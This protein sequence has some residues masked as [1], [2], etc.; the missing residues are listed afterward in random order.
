MK[1]AMFGIYLHNLKDQNSKYST[2]GKNPFDYVY[3]GNCGKL[4]RFIKVYDPKS[5]SLS[6]IYDL[7]IT[8]SQV[9]YRDISDNLANGIEE[10]ISQ[11]DT[12]ELFG[13]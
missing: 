2:Q 10:A 12:Y 6:S 3:N 8:K 11:R 1:K 5:I 4:S 9:V 13:Y 7:S